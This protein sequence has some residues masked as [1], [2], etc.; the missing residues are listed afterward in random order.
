MKLAHHWIHPP[1]LTGV[2]KMARFIDITDIV[3]SSIDGNTLLVVPA[4]SEDV[5]YFDHI[6]HNILF[7]TED[8]QYTLDKK[9]EQITKLTKEISELE[10]II[11][12]RE[13]NGKKSE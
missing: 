5:G 10:K 9:A 7:E 13:K 11:L 8:L 3:V 1:M 6:K 2:N 4:Y 12:R